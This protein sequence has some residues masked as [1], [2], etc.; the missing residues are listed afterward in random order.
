MT[1]K[2][3]TLMAAACM[4]LMLMPGMIVAAEDNSAT[5][6]DNGQMMDQA[7]PDSADNPEASGNPGGGDE[8]A[9][10]ENGQG[11]DETAPSD[12]ESTDEPMDEPADTPQ[13]E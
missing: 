5:P 9:M 12:G 7:N 1:T 8:S 10:P 4:G 2:L 11:S 13:A 6:S 3:K